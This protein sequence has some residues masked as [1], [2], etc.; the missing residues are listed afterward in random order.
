MAFRELKKA[1]GH[2]R[3]G[4]IGEVNFGINITV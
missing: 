1:G 2:W 4:M 3:I